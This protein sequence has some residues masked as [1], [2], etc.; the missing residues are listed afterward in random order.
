ML[1]VDMSSYAPPWIKTDPAR[2]PKLKTYELQ[3][4]PTEEGSTDAWVLVPT[5]MISLFG[6]DFTTAEKTA[7]AEFVQQVET[8]DSDYDTILMLQIGSEVGYSNCSRDRCDAALTAFE[9]K[10]PDEYLDFLVQSGSMLCTANSHAW[11]EFADDSEGTDQLFT[12]YHVA[13]HINALAKIAKE[14]Y[15]VPVIVNAAH[16]ASEGKRYGGPLPKTL[17]LWKLLA[18]TSIFMHRECSIPSTMRFVRSGVL[19]P[20][21]LS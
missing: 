21:K 10:V 11:E 20:T 9:K 7:F 15:L 8:A 2:F 5:P 4:L 19:V 1:R 13:S 14:A 17:H 3:I 6:P 18:P 16:E 12:T